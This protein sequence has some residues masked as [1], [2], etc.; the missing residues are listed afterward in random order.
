MMAVC[1]TSIESRTSGLSGR[2]CPNHAGILS[3]QSSFLSSPIHAALSAICSFKRFR[4]HVVGHNVSSQS[5]MM[6]V[7]RCGKAATL[8]CFH[9]ILSWRGVPPITAGGLLSSSSDDFSAGLP[10]GQVAGM[11]RRSFLRSF[12]GVVGARRLF[13]LLMLE[14]SVP[15]GLKLHAME[16]IMSDLDRERVSLDRSPNEAARVPEAQAL[17]SRSVSS[18]GSRMSPTDL[19]LDT[20]KLAFT[21]SADGPL[22]LRGSD[23]DTTKRGAEA[24]LGGVEGEC[25]CESEVILRGSGGANE[26]ATGG[27]CGEATTSLGVAPNEERW[28]GP[29]VPDSMSAC[30]S[31]AETLE[32]NRLS[33]DSLASSKTRGGA[34]GTV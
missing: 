22:M 34:I 31:T 3:C 5:R 14:P 7:L 10:V 19:P 9:G 13:A 28:E 6:S 11:S 25:E 30:A 4:I 18:S 20:F 2:G 33:S 17:A 29:S 23:V 26:G 1:R 27:G 32:L 21:C 8:C 15:T 12:S 24:V 16:W